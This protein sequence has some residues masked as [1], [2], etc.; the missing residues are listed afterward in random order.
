MYKAAQNFRAALKLDLLFGLILFITSG[1]FTF[2]VDILSLL[3][4]ILLVLLYVCTFLFGFL[5][6]KREI[7][8]YMYIFFGSLLV[9]PIYVIFKVVIVYKERIKATSYDLEAA[10]FLLAGRSASL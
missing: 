5:G 3:V 2:G 7:I 1:I 9:S 10:Q 6:V 4:G 8:N